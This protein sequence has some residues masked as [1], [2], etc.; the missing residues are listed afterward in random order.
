MHTSCGD[1]IERWGTERVQQLADAC[2]VSGSNPSVAHGKV[3]VVT[4]GQGKTMPVAAV[5]QSAG[6][7]CARADCGNAAAAVAMLLAENA[8]DG[9]I[10]F[11]LQGSG[12]VAKV[13]ATVTAAQVE[14]AW[15]V[16]AAPRIS[17]MALL[18]RRAVQIVG[19][20]NRYTV[21]DAGAD[22]ATLTALLADA[23]PL[24]RVAAV[25]LTA[26]APT[27]TFFTCGR[28]HPSAPLTGLAVL[29]FLGRQVDWLAPLAAT[30]SVL[31]GG[32]PEPLPVIDMY[33]GGVRI[34]LPTTV[35]NLKMFAT[36]RVAA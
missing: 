23:D 13:Q 33:T 7:R 25:D 31:V 28:R 6:G 11:N 2:P 12:A 36:G 19:L 14:Q 32:S 26:D 4:G 17:P 3:A 35:V 1:S 30:D 29:A 24:T 16:P 10:I 22:D 8:G 5:F 21:V 27:V 15:D 34:V 9:T 20:F 18:G